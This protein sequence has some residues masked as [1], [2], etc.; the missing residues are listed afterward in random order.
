MLIDALLNKP[1]AQPA[2]AAGLVA[3]AHAISPTRPRR[4]FALAIAF[5]T[6]RASPAP[7]V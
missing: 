7:T 5:D 4:A 2:I 3:T 6:A 1:A